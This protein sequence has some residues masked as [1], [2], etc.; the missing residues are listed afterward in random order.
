VETPEG[1]LRSRPIVLLDPAAASPVDWVLAA[2]KT[3]D[4][5]GAAR[6]FPNLTATGAPVA[7]LQNG[8]EHRQN[9][10]AHLSADRLVPV[11]VDCPA[12]RLGPGHVLQRKTARLLVSTEGRGPE[13]AALFAG[14]GVEAAVTD[15]FMTAAWRKLCFNSA[16]VINALVLK[17][18][19]ILRDDDI[20]D[21]ARRIVGECIAVGRAEGA[22]LGDD[23]AE[24]VVR[25]YREGPTESINSIHADRVAGR[26]MEI[27]ARNG[28]I[29]RLGLKH[30]IPTPCNRMAA[31][32][33]AAMG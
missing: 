28:V 24:W 5:A 17:P 15:D 32:L 30:G 7:V 19:G 27:A 10:A 4:A 6:W 18:A 23:L 20:A 33:L 13:F 16:G 8:V 21:V 14:T 22:V 12:E 1:V 9:F 29:V 11:I 2:T 3:Y 26:P 31:V 25:T